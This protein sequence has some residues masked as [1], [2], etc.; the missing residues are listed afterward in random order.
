M[1]ERNYPPMPEKFEPRLLRRMTVQELLLVI[2]QYGILQTAE[3]VG[4]DDLVRFF[5]H[6]G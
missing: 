6:L 1:E 3:R 5:K 2:S 4:Y